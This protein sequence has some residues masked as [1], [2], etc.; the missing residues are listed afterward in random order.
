MT[1]W[2]DVED[3]INFFQ[4]ARRPTGIQRFSFETCAAAAQLQGSSFDIGFCRRNERGTRL[5]AVNFAALEARIRA[6]ADQEPPAPEMTPP[7][8]TAKAPKPGRLY[9]AARHLPPAYR[10]PLG[11]LYRAG[12]A[13]TAALKALARAGFATLSPPAPP[14]PTTTPSPA[15]DTPPITLGAGDWLIH[16]GA[17][18]ERPYAPG[19][20]NSLTAAGARLGLF[21][22]DMIPD[23]F[24]EWCTQSMVRDFSLW[25]DEQVPRADAIFA[26]SQNTL[27]DLQA[28]LERRHRRVPP[29]SRL[30]P[31]GA[32]RIIGTR[33]AR[34]LPDPYILMVGTIEARKNH[35]GMLRVW[36]QLLHTPPANG[37]PLLVFAGKEG[38][39]TKDLMQ[40]LENSAYLDGRILF[41]DQ[42][43]ETQ[44]AALYQ[45]CL[46]TLYPSFYEGWGLP[47]TESLCYG[48]PVL[49]SGSSAIPEA[50]G[51]FCGYFDP[52]DLSAA[53]A[54]IRSWIDH[55]E[56]VAQAQAQIE[57]GFIPPAWQNTAAALLAQCQP[58]QTT[59]SAQIHILNRRGNPL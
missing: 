30:P 56:L 49:A 9:Q 35:G 45:H 4:S 38:W 50:G 51:P 40:Q 16:L 23:L 43:S 24:P 26:I 22:H 48:K 57:A 37:V 18:W 27:T 11:E 15:P 2:F 31:G 58:Q 41:V 42:P 13:G 19:F 3:L 44:L 28:S 29:Q 54:L 55:P 25:L 59:A 1:I 46:F 39:L 21:A 17:S 8:P 34:S 10:L 33:L 36:R 6:T 53:E 7:S 5:L 12:L 20:L 14:P 32:G 47:V 52:G